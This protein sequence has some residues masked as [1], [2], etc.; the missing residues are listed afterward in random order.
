MGGCVGRGV[1]VGVQLGVIE[2]VC[3]GV[4]LGGKVGVTSTKL[5]FVV[6]VAIGVV[7]ST[8]ETTITIGDGVAL[9]D[10]VGAGVVGAKV[11]S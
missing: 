1:E 7:K 11:T 10:R 4:L 2:G 6:A 3:V 5:D 8:E 9:K